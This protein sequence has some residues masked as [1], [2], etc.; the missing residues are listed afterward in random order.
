M[1]RTRD[2]IILRFFRNSFI[3]LIVLP[4]ILLESVTENEN[5][6]TGSITYGSQQ[7]SFLY[8]SECSIEDGQE[9]G[10]YFFQNETDW[11]SIA[12][13][14]E[15]RNGVEQLHENIERDDQLT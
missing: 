3:I 8:P 13:P 4:L 11:V 2:G 6:T 5:L 1:N 15:E 12:I 7:V 9:I 14:R 10:F